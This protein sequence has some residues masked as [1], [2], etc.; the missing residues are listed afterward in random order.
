MLSGLQER[1][2]PQGHKARLALR[3]QLVRRDL[4]ALK[5]RRERRVQLAHRGFKAFREIQD[6]LDQRA[7]WVQP[8]RKARQVRPGL[9]ALPVPR[10]PLVKQEQPGRQV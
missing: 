10:V 8:G 4:R 2:E 7:L 9:T 6:R 5:V 3:A 1:L